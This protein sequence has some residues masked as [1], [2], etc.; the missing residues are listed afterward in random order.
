MYLIHTTNK[1]IKNEMTSRV[2]R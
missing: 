2:R 1:F